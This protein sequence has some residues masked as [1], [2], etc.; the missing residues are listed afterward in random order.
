VD[1]SSPYVKLAALN[2]ISDQDLLYKVVIE[3]GD[4][5]VKWAAFNKIT[6]QDLI[7][8]LA[9]ESR[10]AKISLDAV[11]K[12]TDQDV[13][14]EIALQ[15]PPRRNTNI[16]CFITNNLVVYRA[17]TILKPIQFVRNCVGSS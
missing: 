13:L 12:V 11:R 10:D 9:V 1:D 15:H 17:E 3:V 4:T 5:E 16:F 2:R 8:N 6:D 14:Y 7:N